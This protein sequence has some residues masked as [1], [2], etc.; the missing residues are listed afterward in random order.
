MVLQLFL[1][2]EVFIASIGIFHVIKH[3]GYHQ[4]IFKIG[5]FENKMCEPENVTIDVGTKLLVIFVH[6]KLKFGARM[7]HRIVSLNNCMSNITSFLLS[8]VKMLSKIIFARLP[9]KLASRHSALICEPRTAS[10]LAFEKWTT[11]CGSQWWTTWQLQ[12]TVMNH[13]ALVVDND[14]APRSSSL[15][16]TTTSQLQLQLQCTVSNHFTVVVRSEQSPL[17][18]HG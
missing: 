2:N 8:K 5:R 10:P 9:A 15:Q 1:N 16:C 14:E 6:Q 11:S 3:I 18:S 17:Q 4:C 7:K 12:F 13:L